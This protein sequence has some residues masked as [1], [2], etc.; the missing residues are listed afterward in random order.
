MISTKFKYIDD[1][2]T[3]ILTPLKTSQEFLRLIY[4]LSEFQSPLEPYFFDE[5][6]N[7]IMQPDIIKT[8][9]QLISDKTIVLTLFNSTILTKEKVTIFFSYL[10]AKYD[11][12][13]LFNDDVIYEMNIVVP[14]NKVMIPNTIQQRHHKIANAVCQLIDNQPIAG[15]G[16]VFCIHASTYKENDDYEGLCLRFKVNDFTKG[17]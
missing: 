2:I 10:L 6:G 9:Q 15:V 1:H 11:D 16:N 4:Y 13:S 7:K 3:K 14:Y 5:S 17:V 8:W 12:N